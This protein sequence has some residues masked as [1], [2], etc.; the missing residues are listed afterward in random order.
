[1][2]RRVRVP[3]VGAW[4]FVPPFVTWSEAATPDDGPKSAFLRRAHGSRRIDGV[5]SVA[6]SNGGSCMPRTA[7]V[8]ACSTDETPQDSGYIWTAGAT[9]ESTAIL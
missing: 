3:N 4:S 1:M 8:P 7:S 2:S 9:L 6:R 5:A